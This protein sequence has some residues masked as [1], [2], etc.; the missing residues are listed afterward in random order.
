[1]PDDSNQPLHQLPFPPLRRR[2]FHWTARFLLD[3]WAGFQSRLGAYASAS[4]SA[5]SDGT[6]RLS[7]AG[8][9]SV[10]PDA[11]GNL[12][13]QTA[14]GQLVQQAPVVYQRG[15]DGARQPQK[16]ELHVRK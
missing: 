8:A 11:Q 12:L 16:R 15:A 6:V 3:G 2:D 7:V 14:G 5:P 1:M 4:Y 13:I 10:H 9:Q